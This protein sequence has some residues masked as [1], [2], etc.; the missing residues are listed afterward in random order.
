[1]H[2]A[3]TVTTQSCTTSLPDALPIYRLRG[4]LELDGLAGP[5]HD[6]PEHGHVPLV[7]DHDGGLPGDAEGVHQPA[8]MVRSEEHTSE[9]QSRFDVVC[10][11]LLEKKQAAVAVQ[12]RGR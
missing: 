6:R 4:E 8:L 9:L 3:D 10:R 5:R 7:A 2:S 12:G 1:M 11:L